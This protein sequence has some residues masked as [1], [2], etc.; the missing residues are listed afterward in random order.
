MNSFARK[1]AV[2]GVSAMFGL[3][4][5]GPLAM[6]GSHT[7]AVTEVFSN[8]AGNIQFVEIWEWNGDAAE[9]GLGGHTMI[10]HPSNHSIGMHN[11]TGNTAFTFFLLGTADFAALP[12]APVPDVIIP[13][14]FI[15]LSTDT[16]MEYSFTNTASWTLGT[17]PTDGI[18]SLSRSSNSGAL[19]VAVN[20]PTNYAGVS[21]SVDASGG[22]SL[23]GVPDGVTGSAMTVGKNAADGSSLTLTFDTSLC[24]DANNHQI[25][26]GQKSGLPAT[27][28]G[29]YTLQGGTC[30][31]GTSSPYVWTPTPNAAD[32]SGLT[33]FLIVTKAASGA[34]GPWGTYN[35]TNERNGTGTGGSSGVCSTT[36]KSLTGTCGH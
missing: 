36:T 16:S 27:V 5:W 18:H 25:L 3:L 11:V 30:T 14:N 2:V 33:W 7:W 23:P 1:L 15:Q 12:N 6:A 10:A 13:N 32:G 28:G 34:E 8:A 29:T 31:I 19:S 24:T 35:G 4:A 20:S 17:I 22:P 21:H 9:F 26:F